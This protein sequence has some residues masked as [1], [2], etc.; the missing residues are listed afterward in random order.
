MVHLLKIA[1]RKQ[2][3]KI[4]NIMRIIWNILTFE[5]V[6]KRNAHKSEIMFKLYTTGKSAIFRIGYILIHAI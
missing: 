6:E 1:L 2:K 4:F 3:L 5:E